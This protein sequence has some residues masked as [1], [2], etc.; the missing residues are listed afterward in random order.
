MKKYF[1]TIILL[2]ILCVCSGNLLK[3]QLTFANATDCEVLVSGRWTYSLTPCL[4][5]PY[6]TSATV[7][8]GPNSVQ[9]VP[10]GPRLGL[11]GPQFIDATVTTGTGQVFYLNICTGP[12]TATYIDCTGRLVFLEL[13]TD[14]FASQTY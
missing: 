12:S 7:Q 6:T 8:M 14:S 5:G 3:A 10:A 4:V 11:V 9:N 13:F 1:L 2:S